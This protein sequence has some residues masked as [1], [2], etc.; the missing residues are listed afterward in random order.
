MI[1][2]YCSAKYKENDSTGTSSANAAIVSVFSDGRLHFVGNNNEPFDL[3]IKY[4][5]VCGR[6]LS[7]PYVRKTEQ[8]YS[9]IIR[10]R[11]KE[12]LGHANIS[13]CQLSDMS[14]IAKS[15][16]SDF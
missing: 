5:P 14:G 7:K 11:I 4:C 3:K 12:E 13:I 8:D 2:R 6:N 10:N 9:N 16:L 1:C 15:T